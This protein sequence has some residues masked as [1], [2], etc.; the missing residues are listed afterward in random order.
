MYLI[1]VTLQPAGPSVRAAELPVNAGEMLFSVALP[2]ERIEH[3]A[4]HSRALPHPVVGVYVLA[5]RIEEAEDRA[6]RFCGRA[7]AACPAFAGWHPVRAQ[8][9]LV[10]LFYELMLSAAGPAVRSAPGPEPSTRETLR[11]D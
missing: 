1:H 2:E 7:L 5:G 10:G 3:V 8:A 11:P 9:P 4:V 6:T